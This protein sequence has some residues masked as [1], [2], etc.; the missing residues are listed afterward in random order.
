MSNEITLNDD[1]TNLQAYMDAAKARLGPVEYAR[2]VAVMRAEDEAIAR[3][4]QLEQ[5][6]AL[7]A[8]KQSVRESV[9]ALYK[10]DPSAALAYFQNVQRELCK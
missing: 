1:L 7:H 9:N 6:A 10:L 8:A 2:R 3:K 5:E 4:K